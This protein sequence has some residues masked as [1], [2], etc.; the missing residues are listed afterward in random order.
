MGATGPAACLPVPSIDMCVSVS[1]GILTVN[2]HHP[3]ARHPRCRVT[4]AKQ[5]SFRNAPSWRVLPVGPTAAFWSSPPVP[6]AILHLTYP[7]TVAGWAD[8]PALRQC[9]PRAYSVHAWQDYSP[10]P[11]QVL[12]V[13][14]PVHRSAGNHLRKFASALAPLAANHPSD[15]R[16]QEGHIDQ[17]NSAD[18]VLQHEDRL[19]PWPSHP[20]SHEGRKL[21]ADGRPPEL[22]SSHETFIGRKEGETVSRGYAHKNAVLTLVERRGRARSFHVE[23][24]KG[25]DLAPMR[26]MIG[27][28]QQLQRAAPSP[29]SGRVDFRYSNSI[30]LGIDDIDRADCALLGVKGKRLTYET[31][32]QS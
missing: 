12:R 16:Q 4:I 27:I 13:Q 22:Q 14:G 28:Y 11:A 29:L 25:A 31:T 21:V 20:R 19:V 15:V 6:G 5:N 30:K 32:A 2:D 8:L 24:V 17:P 7:Q 23:G 18:A 1:L 9:R 3:L 26:G 10:W